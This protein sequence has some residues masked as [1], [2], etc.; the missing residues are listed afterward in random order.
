M[1]IIDKR[2]QLIA[3]HLKKFDLSDYGLLWLVFKRSILSGPTEML[4]HEPCEDL[5]SS[6]LLVGPLIKEKRL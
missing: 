2:K 4:F 1:K 6:E 3:W 5:I